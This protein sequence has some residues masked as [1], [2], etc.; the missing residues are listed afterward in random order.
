MNVRAGFGVRT[1]A[2]TVIVL[3]AFAAATLHALAYAGVTSD[4]AFISLRYAENLLA[5]EGLR[6][7]AG[8]EPVEGFSNPLFTLAAAAL[9]AAGVD[10]LVAVKALGLVGLLAAVVGKQQA[11]SRQRGDEHDA[12]RPRRRHRHAQQRRPA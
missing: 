4:D 6:Y 2:T 3:V 7:N 11:N 1:T 10:A 8:R 5:G 12:L 9:M